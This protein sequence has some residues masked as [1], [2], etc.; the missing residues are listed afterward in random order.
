ME[1]VIIFSEE[2]GE[3]ESTILSIRL[4]VAYGVGDNLNFTRRFVFMSGQNVRVD[5]QVHDVIYQNV[6]KYTKN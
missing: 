1:M 3:I 5:L 2:V 6:S 4:D